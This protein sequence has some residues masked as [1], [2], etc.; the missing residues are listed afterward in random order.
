MLYTRQEL[1]K[2]VLA[3]SQ[4][5]LTDVHVNQPLTN[6]SMAWLQAMGAYVA[7]Q[8]IFPMVPVQKQS[9]SYYIFNRGDFLRD[10]AR[11]RAPGTESAGGGFTLSTDSYSATVEA[12][13]DD[14]PDQIRAN[15]DSQ[16]SLDRAVTEHVTQ[17]LAIRRE[18]RFFT[19]FF[20]TG[21]WG[22]DITG[23]AAA[24]GA[25]Q[26]LQWSVAASTPRADVDAGKQA[27]ALQGMLG[28]RKKLLMSYPVF[29]A[30]RGHAEVR[31]Q[32]K[33]TSA[34]SITPAMLAR[35]FDIDEVVVSEGAFV[36]SKE[37]AAVVNA[38]FAAKNALLVAVPD[39][40]S[41]MTPSAGYMF[42]WTGFV[43]SINGIR[44]K[45]FRMTHLES[46]RIEGDMAYDMKVT[47]SALGYFFSAIVA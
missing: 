19:S 12:Y 3:K 44:V 30:L 18:R 4:P 9:D 24:P 15:A 29:L 11:P 17:I 16:L 43:G 42:G 13:H 38:F 37:G 23:V 35:F 34:D 2:A 36:S 40:P 1:I 31:D 22:T 33:Y 46:E 27:L 25:G 7:V 8:R 47:S 14:V 41:L 20:T 10:E 39:S 45:R 21:V 26:V 28:L 32:F 6:I 5:T